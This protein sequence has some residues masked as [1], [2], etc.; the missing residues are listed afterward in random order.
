MSLAATIFT[1]T[2]NLGSQP[3]TR[4]GFGTILILGANA[5]FDERIR[6]YN[7]SA[8]LLADGDANISATD[9]EYL[10]A[11]V[12]E[13]NGCR[14]F[15]VGKQVAGDSGDYGTTWDAVV[16]ESNDWYGVICT[17]RAEAAIDAI[18]PKAVSGGKLY[19]A[20]TADADVITSATDDVA[21]E[22]KD[23]ANGSVVVCYHATSTELLDAGIAAAFLR[24][25]PDITS[26]TATAKQLVGVAKDSLSTTARGY[27]LGKNVLIY[28]DVKGL[29]WTYGGKVAA[30]FFVDEILVRDWYTQRIEEDLAQLLSDVSNRDSKVPWTPRGFSMIESVFRAR[31][32]AGVAAGH[33]QDLRDDGTEWFQFECPAAG[34]DSATRAL[35][36]KAAEKLT[37]AVHSITT[38]VNIEAA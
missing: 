38:I 4:A 25:N 6:F 7:S 24:A 3:V 12:L 9:E 14:R 32:N 36:V 17:S 27:A 10:A 28:E 31:H 18:A 33:F 19:F 22:L 5:E 37:G 11:V 2:V 13:Q 8:E 21:S 20:Q 34:S 15:A 26:T 29:G 23:A 16:A 35:V 30:G 1:T